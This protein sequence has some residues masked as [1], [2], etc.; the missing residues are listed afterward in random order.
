MWQ[1][2]I[3]ALQALSF[4][5]PALPFNPTLRADEMDDDAV[6]LFDFSKQYAEIFS[7]LAMVL[8]YGPLLP[9]VLPAG[10]LYF[11]ILL[12]TDRQVLR[13]QFAKHRTEDKRIRTITTHIQWA[14]LA[15]Q[16]IPFVF[17][18]VHGTQGGMI[19]MCVFALWMLIAYAAYIDRADN[20][21]KLF[22]NKIERCLPC[23]FAK[24][25]R[26]A[27]AQVGFSYTSSLDASALGEE[28]PLP[29]AGSTDEG[30][31]SAPSVRD[32]SL[33]F[34][35]SFCRRYWLRAALTSPAV[36]ARAS[37]LSLCIVITILDDHLSA[38][39]CRPSIEKH[40]KAPMT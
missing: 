17:I 19:A 11:E 29:R 9:F 2:N 23:I 5:S 34:S 28:S 30:S 15:A 31:E 21:G 16:C 4:P 18:A 13:Q 20:H 10:W 37:V 6:L 26:S 24:S 39:S 36:R 35:V 22:F 27:R 8:A 7:I 40:T 38:R 12:V 14:A 1:Q 3:V 32:Q 33:S 25:A